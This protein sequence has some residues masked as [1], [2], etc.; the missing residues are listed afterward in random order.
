MLNFP[1]LERIKI[2][3]DYFCKAETIYNIH[4]PFLYDFIDFIFDKERI[5]YDFNTLQEASESLKRKHTIIPIEPFSVSH[6]QNNLSISQLYNK[7]GHSNSDYECLYRIALHLK[8]KKILEL[9]SCVG[10]SGLT[11]ALACKHGKT[12]TIEGNNFLSDSC[13]E[14]FHQFNIKNISCLHSD[15]GNY[16]DKSTENYFDLVFLDGDHQYD[17][18][19]NYLSKLFIQTT[20]SAVIILDDIHWSA[21]MYKAWKETVTHPS[22]QCSLETERWGFLFKDKLL[23]KG[24][25]VYIHKKY[26]PWKIGLF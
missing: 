19:I 6:H 21:D 7:A 1:M 23:T 4:P 15:F 11:L 24:A 18:T 9:G 22:V 26:K 20:D 17:S 14:L 2:Y 13:N 3:L 8:S 5:Y 12:L 25:Y 10:M 16:L